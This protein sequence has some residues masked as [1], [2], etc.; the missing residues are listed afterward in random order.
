MDAL[1]VAEM[2]ERLKG[3]N[4]LV[5]VFGDRNWLEQVLEA[6]SM[7][8]RRDLIIRLRR[9]SLGVM[10]DRAMLTARMIRLYPELQEAVGSDSKTEEEA[11]TKTRYT[12]WRTLRERQEELQKIVEIEVPENSREI[13]LA[14]SYGDLRENHEYKSAK[15]HQALLMQRQ[16]EMEQDLR[17]IHGTNFVDFRTDEAGAGTMVT[18]ERPGGIR[19]CFS[20]LGEWDRD[21]ELQIISSESR[22]GQSLRGHSVGDEVP[23]PG[24]EGDENC[25]IT[26]ILGL[27]DQVR[28]WAQA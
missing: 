27:S 1:R 28:A 7:Q 10:L 20:I 25:R 9:E 17:E 21:E 18:I 24:A 26:E 3:Q 23:L 5:E 2:G 19:Q 13:A 11:A 12:S 22:V 4:Q 15:E 16:A 8:E 14:R 6:M